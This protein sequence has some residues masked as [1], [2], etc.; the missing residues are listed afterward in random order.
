MSFVCGSTKKV[1]GVIAGG[2]VFNHYGSKGNEELMTAHGFAIYNNLYDSFG[3]NLSMRL[4]SNVNVNEKEGNGNNKHVGVFW[5]YRSQNPDVLNGE[6]EQIPSELWRAVSNPMKYID[7]KTTEED[8]DGKS[9]TNSER[10]RASRIWKHC[11]L[12]FL[13]LLPLS[14]LLHCLCHVSPLF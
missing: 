7:M 9:N 3:L 10:E 11:R 14:N 12:T 4:T 8:G 6:I 2:E 1:Q 13:F 5:I